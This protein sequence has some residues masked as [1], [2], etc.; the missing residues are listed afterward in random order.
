[1]RRLAIA[2]FTRRN[3]VR[4]RALDPI[5]LPLTFD[6]WLSREGPGDAT[7]SAL[8]VVI[9]PAKF[10]A[11]CRAQGREADT[12]ARNAFAQVVADNGRSRGW[13]RRRP[14]LR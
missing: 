12:A 5:G 8:R 4:H 14:V 11:W 10:A 1:M 6:E 7:M 13:W 3:Y 2:W 9:D